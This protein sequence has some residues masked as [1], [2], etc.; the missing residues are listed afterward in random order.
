[1]LGRVYVREGLCWEGELRR[2]Q[3]WG[4]GKVRE[5]GMGGLGR[6]CVREDVC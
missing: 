3:C 2:G 1:M 6:V 4:A 5:G